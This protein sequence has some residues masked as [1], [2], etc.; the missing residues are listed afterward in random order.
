MS[1]NALVNTNQL[2]EFSWKP[3]QLFQW[4][5]HP[6]PSITDIESRRQSRLLAGLII[7]LFLTTL[8]ASA[9]LSGRA[10]Q[11]T[12]TVASTWLGAAIIG[13]L[14]FVN[15]SG[16]YRLAAVIFVAQNF[17][18]VYSM[19]LLTNELAWFFFAVM[20]LL[21]SAMLLPSRA[22]LFVFIASM[23]VQMAYSLI[24]PMTSTMSTFSTIIIFGVTGPLV[25]VFI[26][27]RVGLE[28]ERQAELRAANEALRK[29]EASLEQRVIER[30]RDLQIAADISLQITTQ[31]DSSQLL[32]DIVERTAQAFSL[33][34]VS[35]FLYDQNKEVLRLKQ[36]VGSAGDQMV[37][38]GKYFKLTDNGLVPSAAQTHHPALSND[39]VKDPDHARN[40]L[41]PD[42]R[43]E[44]AIPMIYGGIFIGVLD[45]QSEQINRFRDEDVRIM[46]TLADQIA[47]AVRN[48]QLFEETRAA[49]EEAEQANTVK[50]AFLASMSHELRTPLNA[51]INFSKFLKKGIP[52]PVNE[53]QGQLV[54][55]IAD[56]G[57]HLLNLINDVLDMSKIEAGSL[58]LYVE[59]GIDLHQIIETA[60]QYTNPLLADKPVEIQQ[61]VPAELPTLTGDRKRLLQI[62]LNVLSNACKFTDNGSVKIRVQNETDRLLVSVADTG[63]GIAAED[64]KD[65]FTAFKQTESGLRQGGNGTGLGMPICQKL[66]EAHEGRI[67]FESQVGTGTTFYVELP[68][69]TELKPERRK[70]SA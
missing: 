30:T 26:N 52:G 57:Q 32:G 64:S 59:T 41:L 8:L 20:V 53:E 51:I 6:H 3:G 60:I 63:A 66:V 36:G 17:L 28:K 4:L 38:M 58:S 39:V 43:S 65:V 9:L 14:Y 34:H 5:T 46:R 56:S 68:L 55:S 19:P 44:L 40:P 10:G 22:T 29:S 31:L 69:L 48:S 2:P 15:R 49:K 12:S 67:W 7:T 16:R 70:Q 1:D 24:H 27:H 47:V 25:L 37:A 21:V 54:G 62:F 50:S 23:L 35:L 42:T 33:Y 61:D 45:I 13:V 11:V 18:L